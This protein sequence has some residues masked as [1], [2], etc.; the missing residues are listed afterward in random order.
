VPPVAVSLAEFGGVPGVGRAGLSRAFYLA[1]AA[2]ADSGGGTLY[3]APGLYDF[4]KVSDAANMVFLRDVR[5]IAISAYG[6]IFTATTTA[7][8]VPHL[9]YFLN[10]HNV[11]IA[12]ASFIDPGFTP[13]W[14]WK[15]MY[16]VGLQADRPSSGFSMVDCHAERVVGLLASNNLPATRRFISGIRIEARV[17]HAYYG[18]GASFI[19][20]NVSID[21]ACHNVR[22][23]FIANGLKKGDIAI[24]S[25][26]SAGWPGS[27]GLVALVSG[28]LSV[29]NVENVRVRLSVT[30]D[31]IHGS[32]VHFYHQGPE[33]GGYMCDINA[34]VNIF[35]M[36]RV[37]TLFLFDH[38]TDGV[39]PTTM[40]IWDRIALRGN[41]VGEFNGCVL[42]RASRSSSPGMVTVDRALAEQARLHVL[43]AGFRFAPPSR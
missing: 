16:C 31:C 42:T 36:R 2:L 43:P 11:T 12:G 25:S 29:G 21:L 35:N 18:V 19:E 3:V 5:D 22:R 7:K 30:G 33:A 37:N 23:A 13:W 24:T 8:V 14:N 4:G 32:Y 39:Q 34:A 17:E 26:N 10:F 9:F 41:L 38:E 15:G 27:N 1:T 28:G 40:R 20:E 6:A